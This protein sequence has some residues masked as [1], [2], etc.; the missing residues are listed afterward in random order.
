M[1]TMQEFGR[2]LQSA[3]LALP[4]VD[5]VVVTARYDHIRAIAHDLR[6]MGET[7]ALAERLRHFTPGRLIER[8]G[9]IYAERHLA[10]SGQLQA[11]FELLFLT[12][13]APAPGQQKPLRP[14]SANTRLADALAT[15]E[16]PIER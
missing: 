16:F 1:G 8:A 12:G 13:W 14:G 11:T 6:A 10:S 15:E 3:G 4:V 2:L 9:E 7:N 5:R